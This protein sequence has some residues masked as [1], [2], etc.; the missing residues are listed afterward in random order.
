MLGTPLSDTEVEILPDAFGHSAAKLDSTNARLLYGTYRLRIGARGF[1]TVWRDIRVYQP[2]TLVRVEV[3]VGSIRCPSTPADIAGQ[4]KRTRQTGELWV[5]AIALRGTGGGEARVSDAGFFAISGLEYT[6]YLLLVMEEAN[7]LHQQIV[8][9][10]PEGRTG[11]SKLAV[12]LR[13]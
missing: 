6:T 8:K 2:E 3:P 13:R 12:D 11:S 1:A 10:F 5:K 4:V 7:I 9:T